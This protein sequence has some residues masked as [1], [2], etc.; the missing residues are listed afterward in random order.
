MK[1]GGMQTSK[2]LSGEQKGW[3]S[4][5]ILGLLGLSIMSQTGWRPLTFPTD[6]LNCSRIYV[7][8]V[9]VIVN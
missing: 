2:S 4:E 1:L 3:D 9:R 6:L 5:I 8:L 7:N